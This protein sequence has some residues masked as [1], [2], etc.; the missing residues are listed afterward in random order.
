M[1]DLL[2]KGGCVFIDNWYTSIEFCNV[3]NNNT[4]DVIGALRRDHKGLPDTFVKKKLKQGE[5][6]AQYEHKM[7]LTI[8]HWKDKR[9]VFMITTCIPDSATAVWRCGLRRPYKLSLIHITW[10]AALAETTKWPLPI[11]LSANE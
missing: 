8:T 3:L 2:H 5:T 10:G 9:D 7:G 6:V 1:E 11:L 4:T